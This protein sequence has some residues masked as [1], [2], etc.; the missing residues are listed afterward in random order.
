MPS[1]SE[2]REQVARESARRQ[3]LSVSAFGAGFLYLLSALIVYETLNGAPSVGLLQGLGPALNGVANPAESPSTQEVK[4]LSSHGFALIAGGA[5]SAIALGMLT[6]ILLVLLDAARFRRPETWRPARPLVLYGGI[7]AALVSVGR[8]LASAILAHNF[9]VGHD[10]SIHAAEQAL[11]AGTVNGVVN[12]LALL[13]TLALT[14]G[15]IGTMLAALRVG[16]IVRWMA[17]LGMFAAILIFL[18]LLGQEGEIVLAFWMVMMG[19]LYAGKWPNGEPPAWA[20]GE[21]R[22]WPSQAQ[23]RAAKGAGGAR[24]A[25]SAAGAAAVVEPALPTGGG[26]SR[27]RR[28]KRGAR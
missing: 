1:S 12:Y 25:P 19:V 15:M 23:L 2:I 3:R 5:L 22:P 4:F 24:S 16:L 17:I 6:L 11:T 21:A 13:G 20:A 7:L 8:E 27:K 18:P 26:S 9:V 14:A 28:R 10:H